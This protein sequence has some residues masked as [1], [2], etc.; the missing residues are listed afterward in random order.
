MFKKIIKSILSEFGLELVKVSFLE[1]KTIVGALGQIKKIWQPDVVIDVGA[2]FGDWSKKCSYFFPEAHYLLV[3][4]LDEYNKKLQVVLTELKHTS[5]FPVA[6]SSEEGKKVFHVHDDLVGSSL[7][8][9][10]EG[11]KTDGTERTVPCTTLDKL[12][13][14]NN[15]KGNILLK[16]DVQ[17]A[18][19]E[20]LL[21]ASETL[22]KAQCVI[23]EVSLFKSFVEGQDFYDIVHFMKERG[24]VVYDVAGFLYRPFDG[25]LSQ[26]DLVF[27][28]E[29]GVFR[30]F[31]GYATP[32]QRA[33]QNEKF[34]ESNK[35]LLK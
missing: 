20:V 16:L 34:K 3:E 10:V 12:T 11:G 32:E 22:K 9:E 31:H 21:G 28:K 1:R 15:I 4:P 23:L 30:K 7:K 17:G 27:V 35:V 2:A 19:V 14:D 29:D 24:F 5:S 33:K 13:Q 25:A 18:E 26:V 8:K 6:L